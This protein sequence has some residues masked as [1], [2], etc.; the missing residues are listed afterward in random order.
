[1]VAG[2]GSER[3]AITIR[4]LL[5]QTSGLYDYFKDPVP[6]QAFTGQQVPFA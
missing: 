3:R 6:Q 1:M 5:N 4:E 2:A